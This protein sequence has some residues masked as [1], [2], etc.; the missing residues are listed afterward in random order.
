MHAWGFIAATSG[1]PECQHG[2]LAFISTNGPACS[3]GLLIPARCATPIE[4]MQASQRLHLH[5]FEFNGEPQDL[6][7]GP[8]MVLIARKAD[9]DRRPTTVGCARTHWDRLTNF[10]RRRRG[11]NR[12]N[13]ARMA[14]HKRGSVWWV[15]FA[16]NRGQIREGTKATG[17]CVGPT[18]ALILRS[19]AS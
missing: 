11:P 9:C 7:T 14:A 3:C 6:S 16:F 1:K 18:I 10:L 4:R 13:Q 12:D 15:E 2:C 5:L 8:A 17:V 19:A